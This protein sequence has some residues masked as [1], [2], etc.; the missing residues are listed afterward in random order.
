MSDD[1]I[2]ALW[3]AAFAV[4]FYAASQL[5]EIN[6]PT[7]SALIWQAAL[8]A[9]AIICGSVAIAFSLNW[10]SHNAVDIVTRV[11]RIGTITAAGEI[12]EKL[13][14]MDKSTADKILMMLDLKGENMQLLPHDYGGI[15]SWHYVTAN[16]KNGSITYSFIESFIG[17]GDDVYLP[18]YRD[19]GT[20][21]SI[22]RK[23]ARI[24]TNYMIKH[25]LAE[26]ASGP[27]PAKW[28]WT[29]ENGETYSRRWEALR[30]FTP[31]DFIDYDAEE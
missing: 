20:D 1:L 16:G 7:K 29:I 26:P 12:I 19:Y 25:K 23:D 2:R 4:V 13:T 18:A 14:R 27:N 11:R 9:L 31:S 22:V 5:I 10:F 30:R 3:A 24:L 21:G 15:L 6:E 28:K 17:D 8:V